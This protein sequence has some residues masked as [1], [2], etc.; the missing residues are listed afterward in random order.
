MSESASEEGETR[1]QL[2]RALAAEMSWHSAVLEGLA[3]TPEAMADTD[4]YVA[5]EIDLDEL[6]RRTRDRYG[7]E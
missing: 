5:G 7:L 2:R 3:A 6:V 1:E 4:R